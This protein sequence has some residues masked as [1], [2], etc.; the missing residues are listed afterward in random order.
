MFITRDAR[1]RRARA[2]GW[3]GLALLAWAM[4]IDLARAQTNDRPTLI[5]AVG[6]AGEDE[7]STT[8]VE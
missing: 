1:K 8:F 7:F 5:I 4:A 2:L 6:A 3:S